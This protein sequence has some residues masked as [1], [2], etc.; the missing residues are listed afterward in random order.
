MRFADL[1]KRETQDVFARERL[2]S[3]IK[4]FREASG[5]PCDLDEAYR[6]ASVIPDSEIPGILKSWIPAPP[7][8][9]S[10]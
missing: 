8:G 2:V 3:L 10:W 1:A 9:L 7:D 4:Q 6:M 5:E